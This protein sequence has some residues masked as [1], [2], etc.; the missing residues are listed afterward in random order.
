MTCVAAVAPCSGKV[1]AT[2]GPSQAACCSS[3]AAPWVMSC[4]REAALRPAACV[5]LAQLRLLSVLSVLCR[6]VL[7]L[8]LLCLDW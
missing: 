8:R 1:E 7:R 3:G 5:V 6:A 2:M 4:A